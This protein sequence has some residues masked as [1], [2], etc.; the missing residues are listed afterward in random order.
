MTCLQTCKNCTEHYFDSDFIK[1][2]TPTSLVF[3]Y[4]TKVLHKLATLHD[5]GWD[6]TIVREM[7]DIVGL[8][9]RCAAA[10]ERCDA[11]LKAETGER[12]IFAMAAKALRESAPNWCVHYQEPQM[13]GEEAMEGWSAGE[14]IDLP[15]MDFSDDFWLNAPFNL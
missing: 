10:A 15:L 14:G 12:S 4:C 11:E 9:E 8:L 6:P 13:D 3:S 7:V 2:T 1:I 5:A